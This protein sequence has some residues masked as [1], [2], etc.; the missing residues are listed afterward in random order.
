MV[1]LVS[2]LHSVEVIVPLRHWPTEVVTNPSLF[3]GIGNCTQG[4]I[5]AV[6]FVF[7]T[8]TIRDSIIKLFICRG[9]KKPRKPTLLDN[10]TKNFYD[11]SLRNYGPRFSLYSSSPITVTPVKISESPEP[12]T[13]FQ[14]SPRLSY[15]SIQTGSSTQYEYY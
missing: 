4:F 15:S 13:S 5:D 6:I 7:F 1:E 8:P 9:R 14:E 2:I 11:N 3:Q 10:E 12:S